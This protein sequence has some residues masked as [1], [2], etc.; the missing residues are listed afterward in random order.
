MH[1]FLRDV[2]YGFRSLIKSPGLTFV[3][4]LALTLGIGLYGQYALVVRS[5]MLETLG[6][7]YI[8]TARAKGLRNWTIV[9]THA[10]GNAMLRDP[11]ERAVCACTS[12]PCLRH[13]LRW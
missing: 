7:D 11:V 5:S 10:L 8:L 6:E 3:A 4:V 9:R 1:A 13:R 12:R 2:R